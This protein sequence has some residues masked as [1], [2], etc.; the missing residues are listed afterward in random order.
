M[1]ECAE[2]LAADLFKNAEQTRARLTFGDVERYLAQLASHPPDCS[3]GRCVLAPR[4]TAKRVYVIASGWQRQVRATKVRATDS[5]ARSAP[6]I[7]LAAHPPYRAG[8]DRRST[9]S[10]A[11]RLGARSAN[12]GQTAHYSQ[13]IAHFVDRRS[14]TDRVGQVGGPS[15]RRRSP[16]RSPG[17]RCVAGCPAPTAIAEQLHAQHDWVQAGPCQP[18]VGVV[19]RSVGEGPMALQAVTGC[20]PGEG[21]VTAA[22]GDTHRGSP[23]RRRCLKAP[24]TVP[25][26]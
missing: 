22:T 17:L 25:L 14:R 3:C 10:T 16:H 26:R 6:A 7:A 5:C 13:A 11:A 18:S 19:G 23:L 21:G 1:I 20:L 24:Q 9:A 2:L 15:E 8:P 4:V 12:L